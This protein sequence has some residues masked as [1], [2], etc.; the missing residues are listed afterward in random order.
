MPGHES[1]GAVADTRALDVEEGSPC[2]VKTERHDIR[3][4]YVVLATH[5]PFLHQGAFFAKSHPEREYVLAVAH[6][7]PVPLRRHP[8]QQV[9][10]DV[11]GHQVARLSAR[12]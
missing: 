9:G 12:E 11:D 6:E 3:A 4:A 7:D 2:V 8:V 1:V 10:H 5:L